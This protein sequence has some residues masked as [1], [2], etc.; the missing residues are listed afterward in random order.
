MAARSSLLQRLR[1]HMHSSSFFQGFTVRLWCSATS[2]S[3]EPRG[4][5]AN[6][7]GD[8]DP[9]LKE[10][11][12]LI[13]KDIQPILM[14]T[15]KILHTPRYLNG[16]RLTMADERAVVEKLLVHHPHSEDKIGCGLE[17][18]M[19]IASVAAV[20]A[21]R[22]RGAE[23]WWDG[24]FAVHVAR[25]SLFLILKMCPTGASGVHCAYSSGISSD[26]VLTN[27]H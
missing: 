13:V 20:I 26:N 27:D 11:E 3:E 9:K 6:L 21:V 23:Q 19:S 1:S 5:E 25:W 10:Q 22:H 14:L 7:E 16:E 15:R 4:C 8:D 17:S 18:V 12:E 24:A 2:S